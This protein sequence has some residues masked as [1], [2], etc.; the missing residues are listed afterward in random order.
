MQRSRRTVS[1]PAGPPSYPNMKLSFLSFV[2]TVLNCADDYRLQRSTTQ[3]AKTYLTECP[4][5]ST[6]ISTPL[7]YALTIPNPDS[8]DKWTLAGTLSLLI[9]LDI[10]GLLDA[11]DVVA[12]QVPLQH[13]FLGGLLVMES[14]WSPKA[15]PINTHGTQ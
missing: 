11:H 1:C 9:S 7:L 4:C 10:G 8:S 6:N 12:S 15:L 13:G 14:P 2:A 3:K 5:R